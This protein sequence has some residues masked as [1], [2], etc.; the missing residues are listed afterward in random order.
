MS[1]YYGDIPNLNTSQSED[2]YFDKDGNVVYT[3]KYLRERGY[4]CAL[5]CKECPF[6]PKHQKGNT[7]LK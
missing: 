5:G 6:I 2:F 3:A 4:C 7:K 1:N